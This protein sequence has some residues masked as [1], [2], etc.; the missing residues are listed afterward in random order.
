MNTGMK[1]ESKKLPGTALLGGAEHE[2]QAT[3][4]P[5]LHNLYF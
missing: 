5:F 4:A 1:Y 2:N 3:L